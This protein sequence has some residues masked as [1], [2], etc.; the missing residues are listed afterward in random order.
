[1]PLRADGYHLPGVMPL[2]VDT[3]AAE[4]NEAEQERRDQ[5]KNISKNKP[6]LLLAAGFIFVT[7]LQAGSLLYYRSELAQVNTELDRR[8]LRTDLKT[9]AELQADYYVTETATMVSPHGVRLKMDSGEVDFVL[10]DVRSAEDYKLGHIRGAIN[11]PFDG[12]DE[13]I[14]KIRQAIEEGKKER[15]N[16]GL[17]YC[18]SYA[19]TLGRK[20]GKTLAQHGISVKEMTVGYG[21]WERLHH[22]WNNPG[23]VYDIED[24]IERSDQPGELKPSPAFLSR[25]CSENAAYSC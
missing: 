7:A 25:P 23:E 13:A 12:S 11:I 3:R 9:E 2:T 17:I 5:M 20:T 15:R 22:V 16:Y 18:Y 4:Y 1:M 6:A 8:D 10:I 24:Y 14:E 19:C 21:D